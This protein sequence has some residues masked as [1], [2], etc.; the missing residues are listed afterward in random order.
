MEYF[1][2]LGESYLNFVQRGKRSIVSI[3]FGLISNLI[4]ISE[5]LTGWQCCIMFTRARVE[6]ATAFNLIY[7]LTLCVLVAGW[8]EWWAWGWTDFYTKHEFSKLVFPYE[9]RAYWLTRVFIQTRVEFFIQNLRNIWFE[10]FEPILMLLIDWRALG[11]G[12]VVTHS[13]CAKSY[14]SE[15]ARTRVLWW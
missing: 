12:K 14:P 15:H 1:A 2:N 4:C 13:V 11:L 7:F 9:L 5:G 8:A 10:G 6:M 3:H